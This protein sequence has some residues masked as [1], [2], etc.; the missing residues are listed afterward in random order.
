MKLLKL[1]L[2][3]VALAA[4]ASLALAQPPGDRP[5]PEGDR[6][7]RGEGRPGGEGRGGFGDRAPEPPPLM[8][9]LDADGDGVISAAEIKNASKALM[10]LDKDGDGKL[11]DEETRPPRPEGFRGRPGGDNPPGRSGFDPGQMTERLM[12]MD[13]DGDGKISRE[14]AP[15]RL[16]QMF[17]RLDANSDGML[18]KAEMDEMAKR[19]GEM[20]GGPGGDR[21]AGRPGGDRP[22]RPAADEPIG[23]DDI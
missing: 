15:E 1:S 14:E 23:K 17:D 3:S 9:A 7:P 13:K 21:G 19:F 11:S 10:S 22:R 5:R 16:G 12:Q 8:K 6:P 20:R 4:A 2:S 18:D